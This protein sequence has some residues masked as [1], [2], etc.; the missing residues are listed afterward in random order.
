[1]D[2]RWVMDTQWIANDYLTKCQPKTYYICI[3]KK[4]VHHLKHDTIIIQDDNKYIQSD[5]CSNT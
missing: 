4:L 5:R 1:M 3:H 2:C